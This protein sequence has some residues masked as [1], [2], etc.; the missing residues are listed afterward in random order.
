MEAFGPYGPAATDEIMARASHYFLQSYHRALTATG[1]GS[2]GRA[3]AEQSQRVAGIV[4]SGAACTRRWRLTGS[5]TASSPW[6]LSVNFYQGLSHADFK[7][8]NRQS[9]CQVQVA[10]ALQENGFSCFAQSL[11]HGGPSQTLTVNLSKS[12]AEGGTV[13]KMNLLLG[14]PHSA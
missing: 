4:N 5:V 14:A 6:Q 11:R 12:L 2:R 8:C 1:N 9:H 10:Q 3:G 13:R 7:F